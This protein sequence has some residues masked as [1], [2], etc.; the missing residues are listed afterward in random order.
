M[1]GV[2]YKDKAR[3]EYSKFYLL[4]LE[5]ATNKG[6]FMHI[7]IDI[8]SSFLEKFFIGLVIV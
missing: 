5:L 6:S 8:C 2:K 3:E 4:N 1:L 7:S